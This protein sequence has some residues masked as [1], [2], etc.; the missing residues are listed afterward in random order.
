MPMSYSGYPHVGMGYHPHAYIQPRPSYSQQNN[1]LSSPNS[2]FSEASAFSSMPNLQVQTLQMPQFESPFK[3][4]KKKQKRKQQVKIE[5]NSRPLP[6]PNCIVE[7][8]EEMPVSFTFTLRFLFLFFRL[9][10]TYKSCGSRDP[11]EHQQW[12]DWRN[13]C[14]IS[15]WKVT[16]ISAV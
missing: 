2:S 4:Q 7:N 12:H 6:I 14:K 1:N 5:N 8:D 3:N 10:L 9:K 13:P 16:T 11:E 15:P